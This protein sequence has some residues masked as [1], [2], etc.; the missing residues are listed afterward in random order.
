MAVKVSKHRIQVTQLFLLNADDILNG[1]GGAHRAEV[2]D[3][4]AK[5]KLSN[6]SCD[7]GESEDVAGCN[8]QPW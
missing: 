3:D 7:L 5:L 1:I 8:G 6:L 4:C 2:A